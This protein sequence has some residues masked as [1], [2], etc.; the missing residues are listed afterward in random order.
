[1]ST[2][3]PTKSLSEKPI[4]LEQRL[5]RRHRELLSAFDEA[6]ILR[7]QQNDASA[8]DRLVQLRTE[9]SNLRMQSETKIINAQRQCEIAINKLNTCCVSN[10]QNNNDPALKAVAAT[11]AATSV[12]KPS[13]PA[14]L[15]NPSYQNNNVLPFGPDDRL[16]QDDIHG[17]SSSKPEN[18]EDIL[19]RRRERITQTRLEITQLAVDL[20]NEHL[21][22]MDKMDKLEK[23]LFEF[24]QER[25][26]E[27]ERLARE[28]VENIISIAYVNVTQAQSIAQQYLIEENERAL[29]NNVGVTSLFS[30]LR[31]HELLHFR[32]LMKSMK[33]VM[34][35]TEERCVKSILVWTMN[36][37]LSR[38]FPI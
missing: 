5:R 9:L 37:L 38:R 13:T 17:N 10:N 3:T 19:S 24:E 11:S 18:Y 20:R 35:K 15:P 30:K 8:A 12:S 26:T 14:L 31:Q 32:E 27:T 7:T 29:A 33:S 22:R 21:F 16:P 1:M 34:R 23:A 28:L 6:K 36:L 2:V 25:Q 4:P